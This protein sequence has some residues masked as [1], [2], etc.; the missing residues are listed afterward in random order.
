MAPLS[1][2]A[3]S[4]RHLLLHLPR[5]WGL[6]EGCPPP[7]FSI[8]RQVN[9]SIYAA[10]LAITVAAQSTCQRLH[11]CCAFAT[12]SYEPYSSYDEAVN[13]GK[14]YRSS[15]LLVGSREMPGGVG[16]ATGEG[17]IN[18]GQRCLRTTSRGQWD[19]I[20]TQRECSRHHP[21]VA[22]PCGPST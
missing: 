18:A 17:Y 15:S 5:P 19:D 9:G 8:F 11:G 16:R 1:S 14:L 7:R 4:D 6:T 3:L 21:R 10:Y 2:N 20:R 22:C 12:T 13:I